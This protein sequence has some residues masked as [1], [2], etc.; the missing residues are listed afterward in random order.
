MLG[1]FF[2]GSVGLANDNNVKAKTNLAGFI[3]SYL[4]DA[5]SNR[6]DGDRGNVVGTRIYVPKRSSLTP[7]LTISNLD[8]IDDLPSLSIPRIIKIKRSEFYN[9]GEAMYRAVSHEPAHP[10]KFSLLTE[11]GTTQWY[12]IAE[13]EI[14]VRMLGA[15]CDGV[16][17]DAVYI[18]RASQA[19]SEMR[20][21]LIFP[22]N[23]VCILSSKII[24]KHGIPLIAGGKL[25]LSRQNKTGAIFLKGRNSGNSRNVSHLEIRDIEIDLNKTRTKGIYSENGSYIK[26]NHIHIRNQIGSSSIFFKIFPGDKDSTN[27]VIANSIIESDTSRHPK[28]EAIRFSAQRIAG[29]LKESEYWK[30]HYTLPKAYSVFRRIKIVNNS[31]NGSYY[32]LGFRHLHDSQISGNLIKNNIRN[33]SCQKGCSNNLISNNLLRDSV[34]SAIHLA[35]GAEDNLILKNEIISDRSMGEG[36]LQAYIGP[37]RNKFIRNVTNVT[38]RGPKYHAYVGVHAED[39][40]FIG[41]VFQGSA[42]K[43]YIAVES[44]WNDREKIRP[45]RGGF[46]GSGYFTKTGSYGNKILSNILYAESFVPAIFLS[47]IS[48]D[49]GEYPLVRTTISNNR[50]LTNR[51]SHYVQAIEHSTGKLSDIVFTNN[52]FPLQDMQE[53]IQIPR[54]MIRS[55]IEAN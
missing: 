47:Q 51:V 20:R 25:K 44:A 24:I 1:M 18:N 48:D 42:R 30:K 52:V 11:D 9:L 33:I 29:T 12:E 46:S 55:P 35:Y 21:P 26:I 43:A 34:S 39:N 4:I 40:E 27:I 49:K 45:H 6:F 53:K 31:I 41:N 7:D 3:R 13:N 19:A 23:G 16:A 14:S 50:I 22:A 2:V 15:A 54:H 38:G 37:K 36:L 5:P 17:D 10:A 28:G 32:G 8:A